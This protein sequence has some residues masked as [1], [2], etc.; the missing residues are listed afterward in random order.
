M[1]LRL[2]TGQEN[3][4]SPLGERVACDGAFISRRGPGEG[5]RVRYFHGSEGSLKLIAIHRSNE[6]CRDPSLRSG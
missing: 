1:I 6:N 4:L 3:A 5:V 2:T